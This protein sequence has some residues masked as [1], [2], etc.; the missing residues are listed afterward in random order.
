MDANHSRLACAIYPYLPPNYSLLLF[1]PPPYYFL[2]IEE[3]NSNSN[4]EGDMGKCIISELL[5]TADT[6][7]DTEDK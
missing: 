4:L 1:P 5:V 6:D 7:S 3:L 2:T